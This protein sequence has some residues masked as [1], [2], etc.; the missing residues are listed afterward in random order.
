MTSQEI[1]QA[2][3][4][5]FA[6]KQHQIV[7]SAPVVV[8]NDPTLMFNN[9]GMNQFK[10]N[11]LGNTVPKYKRVTDTQ[12]CL[13]VSGKH[14][15]LEEVG[16]D[17]YH[18]TLFEMLGNWSFGDYFKK[19]AI[20]WAWELLTEV[21]GIDKNRIY[22]TV[23]EGDEQDGVARDD[24]AIDYWKQHIAEDRILLAGKKDNFWEMG[25]TGPC[26]PCSEVHVDVRS[27]AER[28]A[29]D[30]K[31]LVN[32]DHP[33]V[34]EIWNLV[35]IQYNRKSDGSLEPLPDKH[36]DTGMGF[37][38]LCMVLQGKKSNYDT[39]VFTPIL[40]K[41]S[42]IVG[43]S[44]GKSEATD[45]AMRVIADH[46]R[47][48]AFTIADG[49]LPSNNGAGYVIRR[50]LRRGVR[51]AF[52]FLNYKQP[53][54]YQLLP[55]LV[56]Q[57]GQQFPELQQQQAFIAKVIRQEEISFLR[58]LESGLKRF[59]QIEAQLVANKSQQIDG[60]TAFELYDTYGFPPDLTA[61]I[62]NEKSFSIDQAGFETAMQ[63][64]KE[65]ARKAAKVDTGDWVVLNDESETEF[66]GYEHLTA[67]TQVLKYREVK[68][69]KKTL[70]QIV[71]AQTPFYA[72]SG[73]Q[74]GDVGYLQ[75][76]EEKISVVDTKK[77]N[78]L[79]VH[80]VKKLPKQI[81]V[82][83]QAVV[84]AEKRQLITYN[85]TATHLL[86]AALRNVLG[87]HVH[88][89]GSLVSADYLRFDFSH[90]AKVEEEQLAAIE[91]E[92][93]SKI[94]ANI[95]LQELRNVPIE[96]AKNMGAMAL[97]GEKYGEF[98]RVIVFDPDYSVELCGGTHVQATGEIGF[99]KL[100]METSVAAGVRRMEA[101]TGPA[102]YE[103]VR[104][105]SDE[106]L[107]LKRLLKAPKSIVK[108]V[109]DTLQ[110]NMNL[111]K[112][113]EAIHLEKAA[114][115]KNQLKD[116]VYTTASGINFVGAAVN[117]ANAD[118]VKKIAYDLRNELNSLYLVLGADFG[119]K[120]HLTLMFSDNLV[121]KHELN[122]GTLIR[123]F[124][125]HIR[126]GGGGQAFYASA[127]GKNPDGILQAIAEAKA[128][129][130]AL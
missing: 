84:N 128:A 35:F 65:R 120:A 23:F 39:D 125:K 113:L 97:F 100:T 110:Q 83:C 114:Q 79:I 29:V 96:E 53:I 60:A 40:G 46:L 43:V 62:A 66:I 117:L 52:S 9:A 102:A 105:Q 126:G 72:E 8:K 5:F 21:Y 129:A 70:Y 24:E 12:K 42:N 101:I 87:E 88:Q 15:D 7:P 68:Q 6:S 48:I 92:I 108:S 98:V 28:A 118:M 27:D 73:G 19:E 16:V 38:R 50:I 77:E 81:D 76:G 109:E 71:L 41:I 112:E 20:A 94:R 86:H 49:Q 90:F 111:Q 127:G 10:D 14:N 63:A 119:G 95:A 99:C 51:Y 80:F 130:E 122:A 107:A 1:R 57:M 4:D 25:D 22:V 124:A 3:F 55:T 64:Q 47:A 121:A 13:R 93:N 37:E 115:V 44:Y 91:R 85:H 74:V 82:A 56:A 78:N 17:T 2:F 32:Q 116:Q 69:K 67:Q 75:F 104:Q 58:T 45:I 89:K 54:L 34:I 30:G 106:L 26:G 31:S 11:F 59:A 61:L 103:L 123:K 36:V 33:Q 18:H